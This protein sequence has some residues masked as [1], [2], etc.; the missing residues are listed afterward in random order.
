MTSRYPDHYSHSFEL[1][2]NKLPAKAS[3]RFSCLICTAGIVFGLLLFLLGLYH[4]LDSYISGV[5]DIENTLPQTRIKVHTLISPDIFNILLVCL[6][7]GV[8]GASII[9]FVRYKKII[10]DGDCITVKSRSVFKPLH[11]FSEP[12]YNYSGVRLRVKFYQFG[13]F[14]KNKFIIELYHKDPEKIVPLYISTS[15][16]KIREIWK[17]YAQAL[18]MPGITITEKGMISRN[19]QDLSRTYKDKAAKWHLPKDFIYQLEKPNYISFKSRKSGEKMIKISKTIFDAYSFLST[20]V[21]L[22]LGALL[23][24]AGMNH[25]ILLQ[26]MPQYTVIAFYTLLLASIL[27]SFLNLAAKDIMIL[28]NDKIIIF[29]KI[30]FMRIRDGLIDIDDIKGIDINYTPTT[31]RYYLNISD[32]NSTVIIGNKLPPED[33]RWIRAVLIHEII[34]N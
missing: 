31:G 6:G 13:I 1:K 5:A 33:L 28:T 30:L 9:H 17:N 25:K 21:I 18:H 7:L 29:R 23:I 22:S 4:F 11:T 3:D 14:T 24:Y 32:D 8:V 19:F 26:H 27:Y 12:L 20:A 10:Y 16:T 34:G 15:Q 2:I